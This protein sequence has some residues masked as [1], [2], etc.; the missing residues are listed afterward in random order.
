MTE[1]RQTPHFHTYSRNA[2]F[3]LPKL[4]TVAEIV[5]PVLK[6]A[7]HFSITFIVFLLGGKMLIFGH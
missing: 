6:G 4:C 5:M 2:L 1:K 7:N 3:N